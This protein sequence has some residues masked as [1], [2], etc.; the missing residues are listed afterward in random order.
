MP[1]G[2]RGGGRHDGEWACRCPV[3]GYETSVE[4]GQKCELLE[5]PL[6]HARLRAAP[7]EQERKV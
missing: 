1:H 7:P 6:C 4:E 3:C 2:G 5:C